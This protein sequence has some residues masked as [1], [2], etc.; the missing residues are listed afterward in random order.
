MFSDNTKIMLNFTTHFPRFQ[1][2]NFGSL[3]YNWQHCWSQ[4]FS[5]I[6]TFTRSWQRKDHSFETCWN[7]EK[8]S[9]Q[10]S[11]SSAHSNSAYCSKCSRWCP[12]ACPLEITYTKQF[13]ICVLRVCLPLKILKIYEKFLIYVTCKTTFY[14][15]YIFFS[16]P[17]R[18]ISP[19]NF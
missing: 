13:N 6:W 12:L 11:W 4:G 9:Y 8:E 5:K 14:L 16:N 1:G 3:W 2:C 17:I 15:H 19:L 18:I 7:T 10:T